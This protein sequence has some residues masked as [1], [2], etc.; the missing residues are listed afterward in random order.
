M[1]ARMEEGD[2][3]CRITTMYDTEVGNRTVVGSS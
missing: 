3:A 2:R 1:Y